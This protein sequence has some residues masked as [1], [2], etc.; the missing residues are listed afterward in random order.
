MA[1]LSEIKYRY[2]SVV[3]FVKEDLSSKGEVAISQTL[4]VPMQSGKLVVSEHCWMA[5]DIVGIWVAGAR[6]LAADGPVP[7]R[8]F[9]EPL[10]PAFSV[11]LTKVGDSIVVGVRNITGVTIDFRAWM[12]IV[13][14][15]AEDLLRVTPSVEGS[16]TP[17]ASPPSGQPPPSSSTG[18]ARDR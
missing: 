15:V 9:A 6:V 5:C 14:E 3:G 10:T 1:K 7:A 8:A 2:R 11:P 12:Y 18:P 13:V 17:D 16:T 4:R